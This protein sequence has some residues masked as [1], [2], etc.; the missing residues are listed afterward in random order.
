MWGRKFLKNWH[1]GLSHQASSHFN[2][3]SNGD[4]GVD[5]LPN[6]L[7]SGEGGSS[8]N[9][10]MLKDSTIDLTPLTPRV[11]SGPMNRDNGDR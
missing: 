6:V 11:S 9:D 5:P 3:T 1:G 7:A 4:G 2:S 8:L 10:P